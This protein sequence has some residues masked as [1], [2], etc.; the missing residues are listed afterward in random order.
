MSIFF[1]K[2]LQD[3]E[4][5]SHSVKYSKSNQSYKKIL[6]S[7]SEKQNPI[8]SHANAHR[9]GFFVNQDHKLRISKQPTLNFYVTIGLNMF[10]C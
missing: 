7:L 10:F 5:F 2:H 9:I 8:Q 4:T 6:N 1:N 3:T